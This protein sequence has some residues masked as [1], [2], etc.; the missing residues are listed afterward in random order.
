MNVLAFV[1]VFWPE[2]LTFVCSS[3][4]VSGHSW[5]VPAPSETPPWRR[6]P[7]LRSAPSAA[8]SGRRCRPWR[9]PRPAIRQTPSTTPRAKAA[10][11]R[12]PATRLLPPRPPLQT[13]PSP[14]WSWWRT[15]GSRTCFRDGEGA[16]RGSPLGKQILIVVVKNTLSVG[17]WHKLGCFCRLCSGKS[18]NWD[19]EKSDSPEVLPSQLSSAPSSSYFLR[20]PINRT[21]LPLYATVLNQRND[22]GFFQKS[23]WFSWVCGKVPSASFFAILFFLIRGVSRAMQYFVSS[24][25]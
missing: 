7:G 25:M 23:R 21:R 16:W 14:N 18:A 17:V 6:L 1:F 2:A 5:T 8:T 12:R 15:T 13:A 11:A 4:G 20:K 3:T 24:R 22:S 10:P 9:R 19:G